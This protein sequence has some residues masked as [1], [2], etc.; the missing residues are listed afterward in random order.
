MRYLLASP[1][2]TT[3]IWRRYH[4]FPR[5]MTSEKQAHKFLPMK[6][7]YPDLGGVSDWLNQIFHPARAIRSTTQIWV[8][9]R[10]QYRIFAFT[11]LLYKR[12]VADEDLSIPERSP[13]K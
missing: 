9:T 10:H 2:K 5:Q 8:V 13:P 11:T 6:R 7:H 1:E 4:W 3:D 12:H